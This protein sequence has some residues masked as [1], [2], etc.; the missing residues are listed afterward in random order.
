MVISG[1]ND[2]L[3]QFAKVYPNPAKD[4]L[5]IEVKSESLKGYQI[6]DMMGRTIL[7]SITRR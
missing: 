6:V 1:L 7:T 2:R 4:R 3:E 5:V